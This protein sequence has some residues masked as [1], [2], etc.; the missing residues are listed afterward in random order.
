MRQLAL[1][2]DTSSP[3]N[4]SKTKSALISLSESALKQVSD[5]TKIARLENSLLPPA[6][7][8]VSVPTICNEVSAELQSVYTKNH[9]NLRTIYAR[10]L[11]LA[12]ANREYLHSIIYNF[13]TNALHYSD[14]HT[15]SILKV[16]STKKHII[17]EVRDKGP[18]LPIK[19]WRQLQ[20]G[21][22]S[23]PAPIAMRPN[24][25][26]LGLYISS[27]FA[28]QMQATI[29]AIRHH[30]GTTFYLTLPISKQLS[31]F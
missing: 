24:S 18:A 9:K 4:L 11:P 14:A 1:S 17:I 30:D 26:G 2:L 6:L 22:L 8:P 27:Q 5:L 25:S 23:S 15:Y 19:I 29:G 28:R 13:T 10:R 20:K 16:H 3:E 21:P 7:E 31:L 12:L